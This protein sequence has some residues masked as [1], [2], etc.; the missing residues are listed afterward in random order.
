MTYSPPQAYWSM[1]RKK[2]LVYLNF[3]A[4]GLP[5]GVSGVEGDYK[6]TPPDGVTR[7]RIIFNDAPD[8]IVDVTPGDEYTFPTGSIR[9]ATSYPQ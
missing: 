2:P 8:Q 9:Y 5:S 6:F 7:M 4:G 3:V 1:R